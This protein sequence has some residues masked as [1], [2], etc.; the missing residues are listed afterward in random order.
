VLGRPPNGEA[1]PI[2][3]Q[4]RAG[5]QTVTLERGALATSG[6]AR[7][8]WRQGA[9][10]RHHLLNPRTGEPARSGLWSVSVGAATCAQAEVAAKVACVLGLEAGA[11]F[12]RA[13]GLAGLLIHQSGAW[14][15]T[16]GWPAPMGAEGGR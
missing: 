7:R 8:R 5:T 3:V 14:Q 9:Q 10:E 1:W 15:T 4:S 6:V 12:L 2:A 16:G 11:A 13:H